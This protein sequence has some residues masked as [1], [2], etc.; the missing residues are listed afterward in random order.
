M[1]TH[2]FSCFYIIVG[3]ALLNPFWIHPWCPC[4]VVQLELILSFFPSLIVPIWQSRDVTKKVFKIIDQVSSTLLRNKLPGEPAVTIK[5]DTI[6][7]I[8]KK[9]NLDEK[10]V[11]FYQTS[12]GTWFKLPMEAME[13]I[14]EIFQEDDVISQV[15]LHGFPEEEK[16]YKRY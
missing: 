2:L 14:R 12:D 3:V 1:D 10:E 7:L 8:L 9:E 13:G 4:L 11:R 16:C 6:S 15:C 5:T